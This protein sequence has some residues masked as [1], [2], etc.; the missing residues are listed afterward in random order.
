MDINDDIDR[1]VRQAL[2]EDKTGEDITTNHLI[3]RSEISRA[4][5]VVKEEAVVCGLGVARRVFQMLDKDVKCRLFCKD[6]QEV[7][8]KTRIMSVNGRTR[9]L[10]SAERTALNFLGHLSGIAT[11]TRRY[12]EA[13]YPYKVKILDTRKTTPGLRVM[14]KYAVRCGGAFNHRQDLREM[15]LIK[16]NHR[17]ACAPQMSIGEMISH[18]RRATKKPLEVEVDNLQQFRE[19]WEAGADI[20]LL[21]NMTPAQIKKAVQIREGMQKRPSPLLEASGGITL[22][23]IR[24][25]A[26][27][28]VERISVGALTHAHPFINV[29]MEL[30]A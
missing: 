15:F 24:R 14:D 9:A 16:D 18:L 21:D 23:N 12:V 5:I 30:S 27:T 8:K 25:I 19:A 4:Q 13:V 10:L 22:R 3:N 26:Q 2:R 29:S 7:K 28:G 1:I 17:A 11:N 20:I 6:G